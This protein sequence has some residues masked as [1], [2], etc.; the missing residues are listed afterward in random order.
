MSVTLKNVL[1]VPGLRVNVL[2]VKKMAKAKVDVTFMKKEAVMK[3]GG[4]LIGKCPIRGDFYE[5]NLSIC[6]ELPTVTCGTVGWTIWEKRTYK[7]SSN[8]ELYQA[9]KRSQSEMS[10]STSAAFHSSPRS[11]T[12][13]R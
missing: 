8:K 11:M 4:E 10:S 7:P 12:N 1:F 13:L 2:S 3:F 9:L 6:V 5:L